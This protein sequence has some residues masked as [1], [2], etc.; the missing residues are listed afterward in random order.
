MY[1]NFSIFNLHFL[2]SPEM[3][4]LCR[5]AKAMVF[6]LVLKYFFNSDLFE[7]AAAILEKGLLLKQCVQ[8]NVTFDVITDDT[9]VKQYPKYF[10]TRTGRKIP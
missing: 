5:V 3:L 4:K 8:S 10:Q 9:K 1:V 7:F 2:S 6:F